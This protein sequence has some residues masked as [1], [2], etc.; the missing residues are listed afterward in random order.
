LQDFRR[1]H[2]RGKLDNKLFITDIPAKREM[3]H[4]QVRSHQVFQDLP[5]L[6]RKPQTHA[7]I[8]CNLA[9]NFAMIRS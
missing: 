6:L 4:S 3:I 7:D 2:F 5:L 9:A 8:P 1:S